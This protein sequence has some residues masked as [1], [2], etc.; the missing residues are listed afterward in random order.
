MLA[1]SWLFLVGAALGAYGTLIGAGGAFVLVPFLLLVYPHEP[2]EV[3]ASISLAVVFANAGS[4]TVAYAR[5]G[6]VD[7]RSGLMFAAATIPGAIV[8]ALL[9]ASIPRHLFDAVLGALMGG[10]GGWLLIRPEGNRNG[11]PR[12]P[13]S[14]VRVVTE[15]DGTTHRYAFRPWV[16]ISL[17]LL[18]GLVSS[19]LGIGGGIIH[20]AVLTQ[21]L[22]FP[23]HIATATSHFT[24]AIMALT[25]T[26]VHIATGSFHQ[27]WHRTV[28][29]A[30][31]ALVGAQAGARLSARIHG[32]WIIRGLALALLVV[33][34]RLVW[35]AF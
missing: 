34:V 22:D 15:R 27:G 8:G 5:M 29:L 6:R 7:Y 9:T 11:A 33:G 31:G 2:P 21:L 16:G 10:I 17:S 18:V 35:G 3:I 26:I 20:V 1:L 12:H 13:G 25:G 14:M 4:G 24:I 30:A 32:A 28:W 19:S 23:V